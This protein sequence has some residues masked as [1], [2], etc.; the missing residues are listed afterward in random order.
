MNIAMILDMAADGMPDRRAVN[1][2]TYAELRAAA[3]EVARRLGEESPTPTALASLM[4]AGSELPIALFGAAWAGVSFAPLNFR[5][6]DSTQAE[7]LERIQPAALF[8]ESWVGSFDN[9]T[10]YEPLPEVPAVLLFTSGTSSAPKTAELQHA[11][12]SAYLFNTLEFGSADEDET[13]LISVPP[14]HIAGVAAILSSTYVGRRVVTLPRFDPHSWL[15][16]ARNEKVTHA[17]VVPTM[18]ARIVSSLEEDP[19]LAPTSL[20]SLA[21]GGA[22][23]PLPV[24]ERA[25]ALLPGVDFVNAYGL[26][27]TSSTVAVLGPDD[28][29][30]ALTSTNPAVRRRLESCGRPVPGVEFSVIDGELCIRGDQVG[31]GYRGAESR[32]DANGWLRTGDQGYIDA[33][34]FVFI[35]GR[36]DDMIIR[37][38][39]N[40]SPAEIEDALLRHTDVVSAAVVGIPDEEWGESVAAMVVL[41]DGAEA[42]GTGL[43][44]HVRAALGSIKT[45]ELVAFVAELPSG[46]TG[47]TLHRQVRVDLAAKMTTP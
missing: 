10:P 33:D 7:L 17:M 34:G 4:P 47:K 15:R 13:A 21:Y 3:R 16:L 44:D 32:V 30:E 22:R 41:R 1:D 31:G 18:L 8:D 35:I 43:R 25:L 12:L 6:P 29:R 39:E 14:F 45:P 20:R 23:M 5:L 42:D 38:G 19:S 9:D 26:T 37:G 2:V 36:L 40:I 27:E 24:L 11:N 46:P 28:H